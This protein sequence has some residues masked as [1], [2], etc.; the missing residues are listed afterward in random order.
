MSINRR[1]FLKTSAS[2]VALAA[3][4]GSLIG[5]RKANAVEP[6][7]VVLAV[8]AIVS[9]VASLF[10]RADGTRQLFAVLNAKLDAVIKAQEATLESIRLVSESVDGLT[11][12][13][14]E[15]LVQENLRQTYTES[16][17]IL[18][19]LDSSMLAI[20]EDGPSEEHEEIFD[21]LMLRAWELCGNFYHNLQS[22]ETGHPYDLSTI[23]FCTRIIKVQRDYLAA[24]RATDRAL[25]RENERQVKHKQKY[26]D[27]ADSIVS[28]ISLFKQKH[29]AASKQ[30]HQAESDRLTN[31]IAG[32]AYTRQ[33]TQHL[34]Q[35]VATEHVESSAAFSVTSRF[36][37]IQSMGPCTHGHNSDD[38]N[39]AKGI[40]SMLPMLWQAFSQTIPVT[41]TGTNTYYNGSMVGYAELN[42]RLGEPTRQF[43]ER[44][45]PG[46][47]RRRPPISDV[48]HF[49]PPKQVGEF[50][51]PGVAGHD[52]SHYSLAH[53]RDAAEDIRAML[54]H[55]HRNMT[56]RTADRWAVIAAGLI[57]SELDDVLADAVL[58]EETVAGW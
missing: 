32:N 23:D 56:Q 37:T 21:R 42:L 54:P 47:I 45:M 2:S 8:I 15:F 57:D 52:A 3:F 16:L 31:V 51:C 49:A 7:T 53:I 44:G 29:L 4:P 55:F 43:I 46:Q 19:K 20:E 22:I 30:F 28:A 35:L 27:I 39:W 14:P 1:T 26:R 6:V 25:G 17:D 48:S 9:A 5:V 24:F 33:W 11:A 40:N 38:P 13:V 18:G 36:S 10:Q 12:A 58:T 50:F 41:V 34:N